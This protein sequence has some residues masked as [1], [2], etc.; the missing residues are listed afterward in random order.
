MKS[1]Q[2]LWSLPYLLLLQ[3]IRVSCQSYTY[4]DPESYAV[5]PQ[6]LTTREGVAV[7]SFRA[8]QADG[9]LFY[10][11]SEGN[12][13]NYLAVWLQDGQLKARTCVGDTAVKIETTFGQHLN[14]L[15]LHTL[16]IR[17]FD[18][19]FHFYLDNELEPLGNLTYEL[20][21]TFR[22]YSSVFFGGIPTSHEADYE[23]AK[24][25]K[26]LAGCMANVSFSNNTISTLELEL[27]IPTRTNELLQGCVD[28][29]AG[30]DTLCNGGECVTSWSIPNGYFCDCSSAANVGEFC[31]SGEPYNASLV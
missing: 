1:R 25:M 7:F 29:C 12:G 13:G 20:H 26:A 27:K 5:Y 18:H 31:T 19:E 10:V 14:D 3:Y 16:R 15:Q 21:L 23:P 30:D 28:K 24:T 2:L 17:H 9:L 4:V 6:W 11:D 22:T 8:S